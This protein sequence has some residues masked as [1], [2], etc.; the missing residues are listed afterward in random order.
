DKKAARKAN[1]KQFIGQSLELAVE[2]LE[3]QTS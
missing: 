3:G 2:K 1:L